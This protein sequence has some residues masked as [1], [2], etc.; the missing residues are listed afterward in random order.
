MSSLLFYE[1]IR[2]LTRLSKG[3]EIEYIRLTTHTYR[4]T[5]KIKIGF[6]VDESFHCTHY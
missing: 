6:T 5:V 3:N 4:L 2:V 1:K